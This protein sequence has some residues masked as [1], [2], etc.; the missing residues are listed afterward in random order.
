MHQ[1]I[2]IVT[3]LLTLHPRL[4]TR[5]HDPTIRR[6]AAAPYPYVIF[7]EVTEDEVVIHAVRHGARNPSSMPG[8]RTP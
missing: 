5:T 8:E 6:I 3:D 7:Y 4:G 2:R 1:R